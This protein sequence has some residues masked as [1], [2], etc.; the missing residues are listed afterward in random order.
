M[1]NLPAPPETLFTRSLRCVSCREQFTVSEGNNHGIS[2]PTPDHY[3]DIGLRYQP[4]L[5]R[6]PIVLESRAAPENT[7]EPY[8]GPGPIHIVCPRCGAD[9]RNWLRLTTDSTP[10]YRRFSIAGMALP[11]AAGFTLIIAILFFTDSLIRENVAWPLRVVLLLA[12]L[13]TGSVTSWVTTPEWSKIRDTV[14]KQRYLSQKQ[15]PFLP[16]R[17]IGIGLVMVG[18][19]P[20]VLFVLFPTLIEVAPSLINPPAAQTIVSR[21]DNVLAQITPAQVDQATP[22][23][24]TNLQV[25]AYGLQ[26]AVNAR[27]TACNTLPIQ[28]AITTLVNLQNNTLQE[29]QELVTQ[30]I[31]RLTYYQTTDTNPYCRTELLESAINKLNILANIESSGGD[32]TNCAQD[33]SDPTCYAK[34]IQMLVLQLEQMLPN[35]TFP[36]NYSLHEQLIL[37]LQNARTFQLN[38]PD[39]T[40]EAA[41]ID[42]LQLLEAFIKRETD[43]ITI[44]KVFFINWFVFVGITA[45]GGTILGYM[46]TDAYARH[47]NGQ[48]PPPIYATVANMT[49]VVIWEARRALEIQRHLEHIQ[50]LRATRN[51]DGGITLI[52][53]ERD[54]PDFDNQTNGLSDRIRAQ[55]YHIVSDQLGHIASATVSDVMVKRSLAGPGYAFPGWEQAMPAIPRPGNITII[56]D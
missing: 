36:P 54:M 4:D 38:A 1:L 32:G 21:I 52:G 6:R 28:E 10:W 55:K 46:G 35:D 23:Q 25:A 56:P 8:D 42:Q 15:R 48:L 51:A 24:R 44:S 33:A 31:N 9:N 3:P 11:A 37:A 27:Q 29:R 13:L 45:V 2:N 47:V 34:V 53:I 16:M 41:I 22:G 50:W 49:R 20:V 18:V 19:V 14:N 39:S 5:T 26:T 12:M 7:A 17:A 43:G 30:I 40:T